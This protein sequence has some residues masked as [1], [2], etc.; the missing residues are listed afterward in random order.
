MAFVNNEDISAASGWQTG[1]S[2]N[3]MCHPGEVPTCKPSLQICCLMGVRESGT[4]IPFTPYTLD[5]SGIGGPVAGWRWDIDDPCV[6]DRWGVNNLSSN[7]CI[8]V[9]RWSCTSRYELTWSSNVFGDPDYLDDGT[10]CQKV[11]FRL[12]YIAGSRVSGDPTFTTK[13]R[14]DRLWHT[15]GVVI[16]D[17]WY[18]WM[19]YK[20]PE[21]Y[22]LPC[23]TITIG[24][25]PVPT[26]FDD[27]VDPDGPEGPEEPP[28]DPEP[29]DPGCWPPCVM[30]PTQKVLAISISDNP[31]CCLGTYPL[32]YD[33]DSG[34]YI[35]VGVPVGGPPETCGQIVSAVVSCVSESSIKLD[36]Q[37]KDWDG[38]LKTADS[39]TLDVTCVDG[40]MESESVPIGGTFSNPC[41]EFV[42]DAGLLRVISI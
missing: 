31:S 4:R 37:F 29:C 19:N 32:S 17:P 41:G 14:V 15:E 16:D 5:R 7:S 8:M 9:S 23:K 33:G 10:L 38:T 21:A 36:I 28:E 20:D 2:P 35:L 6:Y 42:W 34:T 18:L 22:P 11:N 40:E 3:R 39:F 12:K 26:V 25:C 30:C 1:D 13:V 24:N 27:C